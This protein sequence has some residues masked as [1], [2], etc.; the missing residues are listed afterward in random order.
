[1]CHLCH[2]AT[3]PAQRVSGGTVVRRDGRISLYQLHRLT[4]VRGQ[5]IPRRVLA[6]DQP[7]FLFATPALQLLLAGDGVLKPSM[8]FVVHEP[9]SL[10]AAGKTAKFAAAML[11]N[12]C[13]QI[14][15][16]ADV[17]HSRLVGEDVNVVTV[18]HELM[19][20]QDRWADR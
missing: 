19:L 5:V 3:E 11:Q 1:M 12:S 2:P 17:Q 10:V 18:L 14:V 6:L 13:D 9:V 4:P 20:G 8:L 16:H 15:G 7:H